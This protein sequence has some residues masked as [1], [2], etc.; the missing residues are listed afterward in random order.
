MSPERAVQQVL[1]KYV[2]AADRLDAVAICNL[3]VAG[4]KVEVSY[5]NDGK[6]E[7]I[8]VLTGH[9]EISHGISDIMRPHP[10]GG[11]SQHTTFD[12]IIEV[13]GE[14]ATCDVQFIRFDTLGNDQ[15]TAGWPG[16]TKGV[17]E[18]ILPTESGYYQ[19]ILQKKADD[20][21]IANLKI[22]HELP[23]AINL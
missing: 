12:P 20:W 17:A 21:K 3:F 16:V 14:Y 11:W 2:R 19:S 10:P 9:A 23:F 6:Q 7:L 15:A 5:A 4:G 22:F 1:A 18:A 13:S 8:F